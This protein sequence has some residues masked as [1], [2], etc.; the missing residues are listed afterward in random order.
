MGKCWKA[1]IIKLIERTEKN[2]DEQEMRITHTRKN[3]AGEGTKYHYQTRKEDAIK[4][5]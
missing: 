5:G 4:R 3:R 2:M 1:Y